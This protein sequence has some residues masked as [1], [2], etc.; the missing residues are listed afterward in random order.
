MQR[1]L[2]RYAYGFQT[3]INQNFQMKLMHMDFEEEVLIENEFL[4]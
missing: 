1:F 4:S 2:N 3:H